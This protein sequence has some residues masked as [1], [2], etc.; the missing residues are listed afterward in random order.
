MWCSCQDRT[1]QDELYIFDM[2]GDGE[3]MYCGRCG[4]EF[5][6]FQPEWD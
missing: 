4:K 3:C 6:K 2:E 5:D 1:W